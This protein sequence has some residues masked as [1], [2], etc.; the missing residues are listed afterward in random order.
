MIEDRTVLKE[1][2]AEMAEMVDAPNGPGGGALLLEAIVEI[3]DLE[4]RLPPQDP[5]SS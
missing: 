5:S 4:R 3:D 1:L 2:L